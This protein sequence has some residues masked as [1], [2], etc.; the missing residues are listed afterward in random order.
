MPVSRPRYLVRSKV[1]LPPP[2]VVAPTS[3]SGTLSSQGQRV[4]AIATNETK[5]SCLLNPGSHY[6]KPQTTLRGV[7]ASISPVASMS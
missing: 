7:G 5:I 6:V 1:I 3:T 4:A 2:Q